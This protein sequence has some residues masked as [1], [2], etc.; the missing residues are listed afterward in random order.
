MPLPFAFLPLTSSLAVLSR[1]AFQ[2][3][4][5]SQIM[6]PAFLGLPCSLA[7]RN[8]EPHN[9]EHCHSITL[10]PEGWVG[11]VKKPDSHGNADTMCTQ[12]PQR[13]KGFLSHIFKPREVQDVIL[14]LTRVLVSSSVPSKSSGKVT[15]SLSLSPLALQSTCSTTPYNGPTSLPSLAQLRKTSMRI[16]HKTAYLSSHPPG[17]YHLSDLADSPPSGIHFI[18]LLYLAQ[19]WLFQESLDSGGLLRVPINAPLSPLR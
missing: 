12:K 4:S 17:P 7:T 6:K 18:L 2:C 15:L 5:F 13:E 3:C 10:W 9:Q 19:V 1:K 16:L 14:P 11:P 8:E